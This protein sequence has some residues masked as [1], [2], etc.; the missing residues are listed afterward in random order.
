MACMKLKTLEHILQEVE[1]F[2]NPKILL[3]Q[4]STTPHLAACMLHTIQ[5][6]F[7]DIENKLVAD[8]GCGC[9]ILTF[10][11]C[12]LGASHVIGFEIDPDALE[13]FD[14]NKEGF[15][16]ENC[17][18]INCNIKHLDEK[19]N[20]MFDTVIM[21]PPFGT[22]Q[23]GIDVEFIESAIKLADSVYSLHKS[24]TR[25]YIMKKSSEWGMNCK[26]LAELRFDLLP[27]YKFHTK[28]SVDINVDLIQFKSI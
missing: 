20:N 28:K 5:S 2:Q 1:S 18:A 7:G 11:A 17:E 10:G 3:E 24:S 13:S 26:V 27:I 15:E 25:N 16:I 9:G 23:K 14:S 22:R 6:T 8:L 4:Y 21:N 12:F 19:W